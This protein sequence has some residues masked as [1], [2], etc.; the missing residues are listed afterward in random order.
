[1]EYKT[2]ISYTGSCFE[3]LKDI[4]PKCSM[5][6]TRQEY[7][8]EAGVPFDNPMPNV[9]L[10]SPQETHTITIGLPGYGKTR[11][12]TNAEILCMAKERT[13]IIVTDPKGEMYRYTANELRRRG[14]EVMV[15]NLRNTDEGIRWNLFSFI[16]DNYRNKNRRMKAYSSLRDIF[17][18]IRKAHKDTQTYFI[19]CCAQYMHS[20]ALLL[21]KNGGPGA[22]TFENISI[23]GRELAETVKNEGERQVTK[24]RL[25]SSLPANSPERMNIEQVINQTHA[26]TTYDNLVS[27]FSTMIG[28]YVGEESLLDLMS[29]SE[30]DFSIIGK[31]PTALFIVLPDD[32]TSLYFLANVL[33]DQI[34]K[35]LIMEADANFANNGRLDNKVMF[36]LDEFGTLCESGGEYL[37][38][39]TSMLTAGRSRGIRFSFV[40]QNIAQLKGIK[41]N[42]S[43]GSDACDTILSNCGTI[44]C[45]NTRDVDFID[46][47]QHLFG[48]R[49]SPYTGTSSPLISIQ[50]MLLLGK[51]D[52]VVL[53]KDGRPY[54][55]HLDDF[56]AYDWGE[57]ADLTPAKMPSVRE[58]VERKTIRLNELL[59]MIEKNNMASKKEE[60]T[61][62][63]SDEEV[64]P[65]VSPVFRSILGPSNPS[66]SEIKDDEPVILNPSGPESF[67]EG[68]KKRVIPS[69]FALSDNEMI[70]YSSDVLDEVFLIEEWKDETEIRKFVDE[71]TGKAL[72]IR[73]YPNALK[74]AFEDAKKELE[75]ISWDE[76]QKR[77]SLLKSEEDDDLPS[78]EFIVYDNEESTEYSYTKF[79]N[80]CVS[81]AEANGPITTGNYSEPVY[82]IMHKVLSCSMWSTKEDVMANAKRLFDL[83]FLDRNFPR[84]LQYCLKMAYTELEEKTMEEIKRFYADQEGEA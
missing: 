57:N 42:N 15:I 14:Y 46:Y 71:L 26:K 5:V 29:G 79:R 78:F 17:N 38:G 77:I 25:L 61:K 60:T 67:I 3:T 62:G 2:S 76:I 72:R 48:E 41:K 22:L 31:K 59:S 19:N 27:E 1:M 81:W 6:D 24:K 64:N 34:Y 20:I 55:G 36:I 10:T 83:T 12:K 49:V 37:S 4:L 58:K 13:S 53:P 44:I 74:K 80:A 82:F 50:D 11:R 54:L 51:G 52:T 35:T 47:L 68:V 70:D 63:K 56:T 32:N 75:S 28:D 66:S 8:E 18:N 73:T 23:I 16:E 9:L 7:V 45:M 33:I 39:F 43:D 69:V 40:C 21:L 65:L 30:V 84:D